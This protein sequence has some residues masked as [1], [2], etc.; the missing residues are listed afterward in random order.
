[1][2]ESDLPKNQKEIQDLLVECTRSTK[3]MAKVFFP[4][5]FFVPFSRLHD[6]IFEIIDSGAPRIAIAAPRGFGKTSIVALAFAARKILFNYSKLFMLISM[7]FDAA[8]LQ[9]ENLKF[10]LLSNPMVK[11]LFPPIKMRGAENIDESFSKRAWVTGDTLVYPRGSGQQVRGILYHNNRP[12]VIVVDDLEDPETISNDDLRLKRKEWFHADVLKATSRVRRNWQIVY[13]DTLKHEDSLLE[14]LINSGDWESLR[15]EACDDNLQS[16]APQFMSNEEVKREHQYHR[17]HGMLDVFYREFRNIPVSKEDAVFRPEFFKMYSEEGDRLRIKSPFGGEDEI[18]QTNRLINVVLCDPAKTVKLRSADSAVGCIGV[19]R[20]SRKIFARDIFSGKVD[21]DELYDQMF[22]MVQRFNAMILGV[23]VTSLHAFI[24]QPIQS[25]MRV[26]G[27]YPIYLELNAVGKKED[28]VAKLA[29]L[30]KL[31]YVYH[32]VNCCDKLES[33]LVGFP[34]SKQWDVMDML[35]YIIPTMD[36]M[37]FYFDP[38]DMN[39]EDIEKEFE[40]LE[41]DNDDPMDFDGSVG[42][43]WENRA[44]I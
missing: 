2:K 22:Q 40:E 42:S 38:E 25:E 13:I 7:S 27:I 44:Y 29:P 34:R 17:D 4:E 33:Q 15:L 41:V 12:D 14:D 37:A 21:P 24:S 31:G 19:D 5:R 35:A 20:S 30:Y 26:R 43:P 6:Q 9:T 10:E 3:M 28:R 18:I 8:V 39:D 1:M 32:N 16:N 11:K 23:E 36:K